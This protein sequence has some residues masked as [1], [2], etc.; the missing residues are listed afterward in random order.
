MEISLWRI[1]SKLQGPFFVYDVSFS[2][3]SGYQV[4]VIDAFIQDI[5]LLCTFWIISPP[6]HSIFIPCFKQELSYRIYAVLSFPISVFFEAKNYWSLLRVI[7]TTD[8]PSPSEFI[9]NFFGGFLL[10]DLRWGSDIFFFY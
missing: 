10:S 5:K 9:L 4:K 1:L 7:L 3:F 8:A 6:H 2:Q